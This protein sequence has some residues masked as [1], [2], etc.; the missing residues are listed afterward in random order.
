MTEDPGLS[1]EAVRAATGRSWQEWKAF[2]DAGGAADLSHAK[3]VEM[4][5]EA[6]IGRWW[7][8]MVA[9][10][11]ERMVGKRAPGQACN[12]S[13][14]ANASRTLTG[15]KDQALALWCAA[16][17]GLEEFNDALATA[18]PRQS[19]TETWRYWRLDLEDGSK[20]SVVI[21]DK[22]AGKATIAIGH[23]KLLDAAAK[24]KA[25]LYWKSVLARLPQI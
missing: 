16:V 7:R 4:V 1:D 14:S 20:V 18:A 25:T 5:S 23:D 3:I 13:F 9:V 2:L 6:G 22:S 10:G 21:S 11:Y 8:Q 12:G 15:D 17:E 24:T 19:Q